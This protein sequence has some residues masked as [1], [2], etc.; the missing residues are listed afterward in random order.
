MR[1]HFIESYSFG[2]L[3]L[4]EVSP[5][6][7]ASFAF[8]VQDTLAGGRDTPFDVTVAYLKSALWGEV[9]DEELEDSEAAGTVN[10]RCNIYGGVLGSGEIS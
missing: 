8:G 1:C 5:H 6:V 3:V 9:F 2:V 10:V 7:G 4:Q